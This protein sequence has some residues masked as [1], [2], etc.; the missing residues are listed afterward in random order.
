MSAED[1]A[2]YSRIY[3]DIDTF[4]QENTVPFIMGTKDI[5]AEWDKFVSTIWGM[6]LQTCLDLK[7]ASYDAYSAR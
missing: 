2:T 6:G 1:S 7:K 5:D 4:V 3:S